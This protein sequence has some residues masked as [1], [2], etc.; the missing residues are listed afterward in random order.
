MYL[1]PTHSIIYHIIHYKNKGEIA[2]TV[3][4]IDKQKVTQS[5]VKRKLLSKLEN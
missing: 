4:K 1:S 5:T 3:L 2:F